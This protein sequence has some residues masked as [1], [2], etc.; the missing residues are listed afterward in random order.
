[1][2]TKN[3][4]QRGISNMEKWLK[5]L[6]RILVKQTLS[7]GREKNKIKS[8]NRLYILARVGSGGSGVLRISKNMQGVQY[9]KQAWKPL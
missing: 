9:P 3:H 8:K 6:F 2:M 7:H 4:L 1:M 5:R